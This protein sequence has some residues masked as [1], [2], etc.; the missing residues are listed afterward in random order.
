[1]PM[2]IYVAVGAILIL[3][4]SG[5]A[6]DFHPD[7]PRAWDDQEVARLEVPLAR[8]DRS[9]RYLSAAEYYALKV[10]T[11]YR[12]YPVYASGREP[13]G[14]LESLKQKDP[15]PIVFDASAL[16]TKEA[17]IRAGEA[18]FNDA[19][20]PFPVGPTGF[21]GPPG[22]TFPTTRD[23]IIP[24]DRYVIRKRGLVEQTNGT[25]CAACHTRVLPDGTALEGGQIDFAVYPALAA[26]FRQTKAN[27][28]RTRPSR[29]FDW[30][31]SGAPWITPRAEFDKLTNEE[32]AHRYE[33][34]LAGVL[35]RQGTGSS[36]PVRVPS[37]I[38]IRDIKYFDATGMVR[39]RSI[40]DLMRYDII[41]T[42]L[43]LMAHFGDFQPSTSAAPYGMDGMRFGDEQ[44]YALAL[45]IYSLQPPP[46]PNHVDDRAR[47]GR[48]IFQQQGCAG[49]HTPPLYTNNKLT[50]AIGFQVPDD[51]RKSDDIMNVSVGTDPGLATQTRRGT[52]FYKV[53]SLRG[54]WYRNAFSHSGQAA[55]LEEWFDPAR[56]RNDYVARGF[57][58]GP[59]PIQGH[60][61]GLKLSA[62][63]RQALIAFLK[64][65]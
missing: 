4:G 26:G 53:P 18:V 10:R 14:Y 54:V 50:P 51:L 35:E 16:R 36:H 55:T 42:G 24:V 1:M 61:F 11:I 41:N 8:R 31:T 9:P 33:A 47:R 27:P 29:E 13:A 48:R 22:I 15:Q 56:L 19:P 6:Q 40:A 25:S 32:L 60:E 57:H 65:L 38:G 62:D 45:Y 2:R 43:D 17:W 23:G 63:D 20:F 12:S 44:L 5:A 52:G 21:Q 30:I 3:A 46:N 7:I 64:T 34:M 59:G 39:H 49:C 37:L 28:A 58:L